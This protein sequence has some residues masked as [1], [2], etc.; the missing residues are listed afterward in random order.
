MIRHDC[1]QGSPE[2][3]ALRLGIPTASNFGRILTPTGR[4]SASADAYM[5]ELIAERML[6]VALS[7]ESVD[8]M[9]RGK[10]LE[11]E[12]VAWF[13]LQTGADTEAVGFCTTDDGRIGCSP[14]RLVDSVAGLE[15]KCPSP[16]VHV[17]YLLD[18]GISDKYRPQVQGGLWITGRK[19]WWTLSY[20]PDMPPAM[21]R[22]AADEEYIVTLSEA[23]TTFCD[24]LDAACE[25]LG[26]RRTPTA[27]DEAA[28]ATI[29]REGSAT[30]LGGRTR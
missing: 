7:A 19:S 2:W 1:A 26:V 10:A 29:L 5:H 22:V 11:A 14:D 30:N 21:V 6:G 9:E 12:A 16:A 20:H 23:L 17:G 24:R 3:H 4:P 13:E 8:F 18:G 15:V 25:K 27:Q 28:G